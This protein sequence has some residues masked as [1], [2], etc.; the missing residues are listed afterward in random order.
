[1]RPAI[2]HVRFLARKQRDF[3]RQR[4]YPTGQFFMRWFLAF[5]VIL[6]GCESA[7]SLSD[8]SAAPEIEVAPTST[9]SAEPA[10]APLSRASGAL[11]GYPSCTGLFELGKTNSETGF[12]GPQADCYTQNRRAG[13]RRTVRAYGV[14]PADSPSQP[15]AIPPGVRGGKTGVGQQDD[16][17]GLSSG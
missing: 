10:D 11:A 4:N 17:L 8:E 13:Y 2:F 12:T 7:A 15:S 5:L 1:M 16:N 3:F 14:T 6:T 9:A